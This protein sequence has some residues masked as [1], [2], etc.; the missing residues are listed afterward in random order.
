MRTFDEIL[1][2]ARGR[3]GEAATHGRHGEAK[4]KTAAELAA[5]PDDRYL[6]MATRCIFQSGFN[7]KV[8]DNKWDGFEAAF[9]G[10]DLGRWVLSNDDDI[11]A[12]LSDKRIVRNG[13]KIVSVPANARFFAD[14]S[15]E[16]GGVGRWI[17]E[18][19][20]TD[21]IGLLEVLATKGSRLGGATGQYFLRFMGKD[22]FILSR[23]VTA[24]LIRE[25]IIDKPATSKKALAAVQ[26]AFNHW[27]E[28]SGQPA[29]AISQTLARSIDG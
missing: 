11:A 19:P 15:A 29:T 18:W 28:D 17:G 26:A 25:G 10:F 13:Q 27:M 22:S 21:Q 12:L 23:D 14:M 3:H 2:I 5:I 20:V 9:E 4:P 24:A 8:I 7:W 6:A 1:E 16:Y